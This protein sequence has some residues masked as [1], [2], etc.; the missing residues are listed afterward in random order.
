MSSIVVSTVVRVTRSPWRTGMSPTT[1]AV[2]ADD[3]VVGE[4]GLLLL[5]LLFDRLELRF[6]GLLSC[7]CACSYSCWLA[8]P[9]S[10]SVLARIGL[11]SRKRR[12]GLARGAD[13]LE[14]RHRGLLRRRVDLEH[15]RAGRHAIAGLHEDRVRKP[16][17][18]G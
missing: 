14:A 16:S 8:A 5:D 6:G 1:P 10:S 18:C 4:L 7:A 3:V 9:T 13:R 2:G 15:R 12:I 11:L 17:A